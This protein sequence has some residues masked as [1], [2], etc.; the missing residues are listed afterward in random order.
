MW[1]QLVIESRNLARQVYGLE[2]LGHEEIIR[3]VIAFVHTL[4]HQLRQSSAEQEWLRL[5]ELKDIEYLRTR[6]NP[7]SA[8]LVFIAKKINQLASQKQINSQQ[9]ARLDVTLGQL[10]EV[11]GGCERI[12]NTPLPYTYSVILHRTVY[13]YCM[14]LPFGLLDGLGVMTPLMVTLVAY[15]FF[16]LEALSD[17]IE[18][19]FGIMAN[20]LPLHALSVGIEISLLDMIGHNLGQLEVIH[21]KDYILR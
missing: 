9:W 20:D 15:T 21:P 8:L 7:A 3:Y 11:L 2:L 13:L 17:E 16:A 18:E 4:R 6:Q 14:L 12:A 5:L 19:P 10:S 1:G